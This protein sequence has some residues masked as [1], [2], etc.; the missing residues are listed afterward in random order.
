[1]IRFLCNHRK[2]ADELVSNVRL[3]LA[4]ILKIIWLSFSRAV[5]HELIRYW[6]SNVD[7]LSS[8]LNFIISAVITS[9]GVRVRFLSYLSHFF[10]LK[11]LTALSWSTRL[12]SQHLK[13]SQP[14]WQ[15]RC[16]LSFSARHRNC[17]CFSV[18]FCCKAAAYNTMIA[19]G[20]S[21]C[22]VTECSF[23]VT[24]KEMTIFWVTTA[25]SLKYPPVL[26]PYYCL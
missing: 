11:A 23:V 20:V 19:D 24:W 2:K 16:E 12:S 13:I 4:G 25:F 21:T 10:S 3:S 6:Q 15:D 5:H 22:A 1:M 9:K 18:E 26:S 14:Q 8:P 7:F 17:L